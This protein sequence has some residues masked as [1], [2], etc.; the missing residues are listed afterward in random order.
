VKKNGTLLMTLKDGEV[1]FPTLTKER[2]TIGVD[3][4]C[5][6]PGELGE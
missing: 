4:E 1:T 5:G 2:Q 3:R 6:E